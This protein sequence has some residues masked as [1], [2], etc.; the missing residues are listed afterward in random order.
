M[1]KFALIYRNATPPG[2]PEDGQKHMAAW[3]EWSSGLGEALI[4]PGMP[5][6]KAVVVSQN[7]TSSQ[8]ENA[9]YDGVS[10]V[11]TESIEQAAEMAARCPHLYLG[12]DMVVAE[13]L[14]MEM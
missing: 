7:G 2:T 3:Q 10:I 1:P 12:G 4:E 14:E 13:G 9:K 5:F 8:I 6:S 11:E